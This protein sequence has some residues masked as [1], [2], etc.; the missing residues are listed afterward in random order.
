MQ[1]GGVT[2]TLTISLHLPVNKYQHHPSTM[3]LPTPEEVQS[4]IA[5]IANVAQAYSASLDLNGYISR[6]QVIAKAKKLA[7][8]LISPEQ[9]PNYHGLNVRLLHPFLSVNSLLTRCLFD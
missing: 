9:L 1:A 2:R 3:A 7:Q 5:E 6:V 4:L 8:S